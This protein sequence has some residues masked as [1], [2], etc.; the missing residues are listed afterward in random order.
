MRLALRDAGPATA[1]SE[2][3]GEV[4]SNDYF[5]H[6]ASNLASPD[7]EHESAAFPCPAACEPPFPAWPTPPAKTE[8]DSIPIDPGPAQF[9]AF[10]PPCSGHNFGSPPWY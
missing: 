1:C 8:N 4:R 5:T 3:E 10:Y 9:N 6:K 2:A 7:S